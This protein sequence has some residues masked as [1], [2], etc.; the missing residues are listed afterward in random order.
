[1]SDGREEKGIRE[2]ILEAGARAVTRA[3]ERVLSN[4]I[5]QDVVARAVG[6]A[7]R[8]AQ[9]AGEV[10]E[11][12]LAAAGIPGRQDYQRLEKE[13]ARLRRRVRELSA[14]LGDEPEQGEGPGIGGTRE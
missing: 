3:A 14:K 7:Q 1:M 8:G 2:R 6:M 10:H 5:G 4:P 11:R 13:L 9:R 12:L